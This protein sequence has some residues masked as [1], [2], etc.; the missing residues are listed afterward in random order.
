MYWI[1]HKK[2]LTC[3]GLPT[4]KPNMYWIAHKK[5]NMDCIAHKKVNLMSALL[6]NYHFA[7]FNTHLLF[8]FRF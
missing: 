2:V 4:K 1:A 6:Q 3:I 8:F 5:P 7:F